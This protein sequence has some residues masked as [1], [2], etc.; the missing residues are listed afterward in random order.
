MS[1][2]ILKI[3]II[4]LMMLLMVKGQQ[5]NADETIEDEIDAI[6]R[7]LYQADKYEMHRKALENAFD[8]L[9]SAYVQQQQVNNDDDFFEEDEK[10]SI[11]TLAKNGQLPSR[12]PDTIDLETLS[13][14]DNGHKRNIAS[15]ARSGLIGGKRNIQS[16]AR[17]WQ[18]ANSGKRNIGALMRNNMFPGSGKRNVASLARNGFGKRN[19]GALARDFMLP[20]VNSGAKYTDDGKRNIQALKNSIKGR[21]KREIG[22]TE[23]NEP[24]FQ[25]GPFDYEDLLQALNDDGPYAEKRFLAPYEYMPDNND[26]ATT[27]TLEKRHLGSL[28]RSGWMSSFRPIRNRFSRSGRTEN[29]VEQTA[30]YYFP[31]D[32]HPVPLVGTSCRRC[33]LDRQLTKFG[34]GIMRNQWGI[35]DNNLP[36]FGSLSSS[37]RTQSGGNS[38]SPRVAALSWRTDRW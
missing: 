32:R 8:R 28:A 9:L 31:L 20:K 34:G 2:I 38:R 37:V 30:E 18:Y 36:T 29:S 3:G 1:Q 25:N 24:V 35:N 6:Q 23:V 13:D 16:L 27:I 17:Q 19:V 4:V 22:E 21:K 14:D 7:A 12:E 26:I 10:R 33:E 11:A 5:Y 15:M